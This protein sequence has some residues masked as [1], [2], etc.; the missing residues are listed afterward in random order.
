M[1]FILEAIWECGS[2][3]ARHFHIW[4]DWH[5]LAILVEIQACHLNSEPHR[6]PNQWVPTAYQIWERDKIFTYFGSHGGVY[7]SRNPSDVLLEHEISLFKKVCSL[8]YFELI[9][10]VRLDIGVIN[11]ISIFDTNHIDLYWLYL[12]GK[13]G[14]DELRSVYRRHLFKNIFF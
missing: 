13:I 14:R 6:I 3:Y 4:R 5:E 7:I 12:P 10:C 1:I 11:S 2:V 9:F 8:S